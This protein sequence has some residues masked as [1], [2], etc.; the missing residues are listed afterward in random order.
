[1]T[2]VRNFF[3]LAR[4]YQRFVQK[5]SKI[6]EP[7]TKLMHEGERYIRTNECNSAFEKLKHRLTTT[8]VLTIL[9]ISRDMVVYSDAC[10]M[11]RWLLTPID[12]LGLRKRISIPWN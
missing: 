8:S 7:L 11:V 2:K 5:I 10:S 12:S 6:V 4:Y 3:G 9:D 1:M